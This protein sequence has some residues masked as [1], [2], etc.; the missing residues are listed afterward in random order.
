MESNVIIVLVILA[1]ISPGIVCFFIR[2]WNEE[3][4][5][6]KLQA[7]IDQQN[8]LESQEKAVYMELQAEEAVNQ[9]FMLLWTK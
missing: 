6:K 3:T 4:D 7:M 2:F 8:A 9:G 5:L 1:F